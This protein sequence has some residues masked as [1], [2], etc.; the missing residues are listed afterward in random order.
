ME[1]RL[2]EHRVSFAA[3][4][5]EVPCRAKPALKWHTD[6]GGSPS[7]DHLP[8]ITSQYNSIDTHHAGRNTKAQGILI[9]AATG[10]DASAR[11]DLNAYELCYSQEAC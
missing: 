8:S 1:H 11:D 5:R 3:T 6:N 7:H 4:T 2:R 9:V 10:C